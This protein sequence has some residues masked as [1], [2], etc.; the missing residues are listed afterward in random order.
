M[1]ALAEDPFSNES[2]LPMFLAPEDLAIVVVGGYGR[3]S[4]WMPTFGAATR[5]VTYMVSRYSG[6][7]VLVE[8]HSGRCGRAPAAARACHRSVAERC[9]NSS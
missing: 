7:L 6:F 9:S 5:S 1:S 3:H 4:F 8:A 2:A